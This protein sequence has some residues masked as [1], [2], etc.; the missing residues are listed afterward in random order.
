MHPTSRLNQIVQIVNPPAPGQ[1]SRSADYQ[2]ARS[3]GPDHEPAFDCQLV[4]VF[5]YNHSNTFNVTG[6]AS[7]E[8]ARRA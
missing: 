7:H 6:L 4:L 3:G 8:K 5:D 2:V 1:V